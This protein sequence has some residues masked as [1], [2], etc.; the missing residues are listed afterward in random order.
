MTG[1]VVPAAEIAFVRD[2]PMGPLAVRNL[3][4]F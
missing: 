4:N 2:G 3:V 1:S